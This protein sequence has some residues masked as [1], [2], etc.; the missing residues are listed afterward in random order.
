MVIKSKKF[1]SHITPGDQ[2]TWKDETYLTLDIDWAPDYV[3]ADT[4]ELLLK[5]NVAA[6]ILVTHDTFLIRELLNE[7]NFEIGIHPNF[8]KLPNGSKEKGENAKQVIE[9]LLEIVPNPKVVRSH[10]MTSNSH[11][12]HYFKT[13]KITHDLNTF[14]PV[15]AEMKLKPFFS[16]NGLTRV[17]YCWEDDIHLLYEQIGITEKEPK[18]IQSMINFGVKVI[19][20][21]PIHIYLNTESLDRYENSRGFHRNLEK[22]QEYRYQGYGTRD[23]FIE[24]ISK[25]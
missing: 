7:K 8:N 18:D 4:I 13:Y 3:I 10:S 24:L 12:L 14:I 25:L 17:P 21:H 19:N 16:W 11:L 9:R 1:I 22:L 23:R 5:Y 20:F 6:T 15:G 2:L